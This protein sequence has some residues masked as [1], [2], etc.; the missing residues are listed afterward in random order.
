MT[1]VRRLA[2]SS[3]AFGAKLLALAGVGFAVRVAYGLSVGEPFGDATFYHEV[4]NRLADGQGYQHPSGVPTAA[5]PP[6][7]PLLLSAVSFV[8]MT[9]KDAHQIAGCALGGLT[10]VLIGL[11]GRRLAG[12]RAGL[13][14]AMVAAVYLPLIVNDSLLYSESA[15]GATIALVLLI[16]LWAWERPTGTRALALGAATG[17]AALG[18][19]EAL[20]LVPL[21]AVPLALRRSDRRWQRAALV[22]VGAALVVVP[23][24]GRNW[25]VFDRPVLISTNDASVL[26][27]ANCD[28]T[29]GRL[30]GQWDIGCLRGRVGPGENEAVVAER[31]RDAGLRY[32]RE[33][34]GEV[35]RVVAARVGRTWSIYGAREQV[36]L[37]SFLRGSPSWLEWLTVASFAAAAALAVAGAILVKRRSG[38][39]WILLAPLVVVTITS[40]VGYG[41]PRFRQAAEV[42]IVLLAAIALSAGL[43][44]LRQPQA[45]ASPRPGNVMLRGAP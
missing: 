6:L 30:L 28:S 39:L 27:G 32:A 12:S 44:A 42:P 5:H 36:R 29:Y 11:A 31:W 2:D 20:L 33:H 7:F 37:N 1:S 16:A 10:V 40:A 35:P 41:T 45:H 4:A 13:V 15:Y 21:L 18:R 14:A 3:T 9:S 25:I 24:T 19:G 34:A 43:N 8:G 22:F 17:L 38:P 23:W 26:G